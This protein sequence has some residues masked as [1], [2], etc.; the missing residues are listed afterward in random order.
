MKTLLLIALTF[1]PVAAAP[2]DVETDK[3]EILA[4]VKKGVE[5][6]VEVLKNKELS[7]DERRKQV[8]KIIDPLIDFQLLAMLSLGK[9]HWNAADAKQRETFTELFV[10]TVKLSYLEKLELFTDEVVEFDEPIPTSTKGSPKYSMLT[11]IVSKGDRIKVDYHITKR[12]DIWKAYD[13]EIEG[14]SIRKSYGAQYNDYLKQ[15]SFDELL[16]TMREKVEEARKKGSQSAGT[17]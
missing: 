11:Y 2:A 15:A 9:K 4:V 3:R 5:E 6:V 1:G 14:V 7:G 13:F 16:A 12:D 10:E 17:Q 8:T